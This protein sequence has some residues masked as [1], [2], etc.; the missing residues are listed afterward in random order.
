MMSLVANDPS[1][2]DALATAHAAWPGI[3]VSAH[4]FAGHVTRLGLSALALARR[5]AEVY[6]ALACARGDAAALQI[7]DATLLPGARSQMG[8]MGITG[9]WEEELLQALRVRLLVGTPPRIASYKGEGALEAWVRV[10]AA[11]MALN[12]IE[13]RNARTR[14]TLAA[15]AEQLVLRSDPE[16]KV[17]KE[18]FR[19]PLAEALEAALAAL[20][21]REKTLLRLHIL[22][23]LSIDE[24]GAIYRVHRATAARWLVGIRG[25]V[26]ATVRNHLQLPA[27][28]TSSEFRSIVALLRDELSVSVARALAG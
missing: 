5:G 10:A 28:P 20:S 21:P 15:H 26:L 23:N 16:L 9:A 3:Q 1:V 18:T 12:D 19:Q 22:D 27:R 8:R 11:H 13:A 17:D 14:H 4:D 7:F 24:I 25:T 6:L 2:R